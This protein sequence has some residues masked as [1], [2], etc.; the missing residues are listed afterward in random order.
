[1]LYTSFEPAVGMRLFK[2][3]DLNYLFALIMSM[4]VNYFFFIPDKAYLV[5][6][7]LLCGTI[8]SCLIFKTRYK[9]YDKDVNNIL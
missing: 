7:I 8:V 6:T 9:N 1:M 3:Y 4:T 5:F 2:I